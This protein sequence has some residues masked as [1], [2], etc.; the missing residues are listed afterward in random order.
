MRS[1][2]G[3]ECRKLFRKMLAVELPNYQADKTQVM[4]QGLYAWKHQHPSGLFFGIFLV[5]HHSRDEFTTEVG[6]SFN[7]VKP[8]WKMIGYGKAEAVLAEPVAFRSS[9]LWYDNNWDFWWKLVLRR[10]EYERVLLYKDD[11]VEECLPLISPAVWDAGEK[12]KEYAIPIFE[13]IVRKY[14]S[15]Q[16]K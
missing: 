12:L 13:E 3:K 8:P 1:E 6:W 10:E 5:I 7:A 4:P 16:P 14:G 11:P 9:D 2:L 15:T